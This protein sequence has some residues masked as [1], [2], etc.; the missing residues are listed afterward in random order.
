MGC[1]DRYDITASASRLPTLRFLAIS[2]IHP[3]GGA[4]A[5]GTPILLG[6]QEVSWVIRRC[7]PGRPRSGTRLPHVPAAGRPG[8]RGRTWLTAE[9]C[10][11]GGPGPRRAA[12]AR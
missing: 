2:P 8:T 12:T 7:A 1:C 4:A 5:G 6:D 9:R 3:N 11:R 10:H